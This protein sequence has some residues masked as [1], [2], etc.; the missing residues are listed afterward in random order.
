MVAQLKMRRRAQLREKLEV[1]IY[2]C[3]CVWVRV[4]ESIDRCMYEKLGRKREQMVNPKIV[5]LYICMYV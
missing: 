2:I 5:S 1:Y 3:I 4:Y